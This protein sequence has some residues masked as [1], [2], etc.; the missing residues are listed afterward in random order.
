MAIGAVARDHNGTLVAALSQ[1][2]SSCQDA[3]EAEA[4]AIL[5]GLQLGI[6]LNLNLLVLESTA[7][8]QCWRQTALFQI[9]RAHV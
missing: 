9:G 6:D 7:V 4:K 3:E 5:A 2:T 8:L 1:T